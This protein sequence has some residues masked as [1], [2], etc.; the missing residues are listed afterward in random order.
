MTFQTYEGLRLL[1]LIFCGVFGTALI[2][3]A[4]LFTL[5]N[6]LILN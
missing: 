6:Y 2:H 4:Y 3:L 1:L 5:F